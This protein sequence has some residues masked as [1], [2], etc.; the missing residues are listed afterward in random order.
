MTT[1]PGT[2]PKGEHTKREYFSEMIGRTRFVVLIAVIAVLLVAFSLFLQG[3]LLALTTIYETWRGTFTEGI[4]SQ[5][6]TL[7]VEFLEVVSTMLKAVVFYIIGVG[8]YSLF[9]RPLNLTSALGVESLSDLEQKVV[10]V[11]IVILGVTFLEH[12]IRWE[13]PQETLYFAGSLALAGAP[14]CS[15]SGSTGVRAGTSSSP[16]PNCGPG[17]SCSSTTA[18]SAKSARRTCGGPSGR[19][20]PRP[21]DRWRRRRARSRPGPTAVRNLK[22]TARYG[23]PDEDVARA[24]Q[25]RAPGRPPDRARRTRFGG[26]SDPSARRAPR[27][28]RRS[29]A[30]PGGAR[31]GFRGGRLRNEVTVLPDGQVNPIGAGSKAAP[32]FQKGRA[33]NLQATCISASG[34]FQ[35][36]ELTFK[37]EGRTVMVVFTKAGF[38]FKRGGIAY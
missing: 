26:G 22:V 33:Y 7:A 10:S 14:W 15:F 23:E 17:A 18:S 19:P 3:T 1:R 6:G 28:Q 34:T 4:G 35:N 21:R 29:L 31:Q 5:S 8:L 27:R 12:F 38:Q 24:F 30:V 2:R 25:P 11:V 13:D 36:S 37:A 20:R 16:R 9:I 32:R